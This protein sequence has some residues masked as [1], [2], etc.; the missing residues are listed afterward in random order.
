MRGKENQ[1]DL[2]EKR[3]AC[4][5]LARDLSAG[6]D[7]PAT[8]PAL[9]LRHSLGLLVLTLLHHLFITN[10]FDLSLLL[11]LFS[12]PTPPFTSRSTLHHPEYSPFGLAVSDPPSKLRRLFIPSSTPF[13]P[14]SFYIFPFYSLFISVLLSFFSF[15]PSFFQ[16]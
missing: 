10:P 2:K 13:S 3:E 11:P 15:L 4:R 16:K 8:A 5:N 6:H 12:T 7:G 9:R 14:F 1:K